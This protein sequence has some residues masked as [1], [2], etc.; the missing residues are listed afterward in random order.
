MFSPDKK[1]ESKRENN[2]YL[3]KYAALATQLLV[4]LGL[5]VWAG[6]KLDKWWHSPI[7]LLGWLLPL[8]VLV[9]I[10]YQI[11]KDTSPKK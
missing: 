8:L 7:P 10:L 5:A 1:E 3:M 6:L 4:S 2:R 9:V 11:V